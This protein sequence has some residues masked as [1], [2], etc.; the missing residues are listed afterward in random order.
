M[1][2]LPV[3]PLIRLAKEAG[4]ERISD[5]AKEMFVGKACEA[6]ITLWKEANEKAVADK[7]VT[8]LPRDLE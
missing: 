3:A 5:E 6:I 4:V 7:R 2:T 1:A 8:I